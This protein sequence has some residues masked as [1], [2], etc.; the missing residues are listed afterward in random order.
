M[1]KYRKWTDE[2]TGVNPFIIADQ[3]K[4]NLLYNITTIVFFILYQIKSTLVLGILI[5]IVPLIFSASFLPF[6]SIIY[7]VLLALCGNI[8]SF[9]DN[10]FNNDLSKLHKK[11]TKIILS[12]FCSLTDPIYFMLKYL[13]AYFRVPNSKFLVIQ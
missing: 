2:A 11:N 12:N 3:K 4:F 5:L 6:L 9:D 1:E 7:S 10:K 8:F 13:L